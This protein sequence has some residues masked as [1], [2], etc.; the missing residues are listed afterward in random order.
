MNW[1]DYFTRRCICRSTMIVKLLTQC[2]MDLES[3]CLN[4]RR[5][6]INA[7]ALMKQTQNST[8]VKSGVKARH[9]HFTETKGEINDESYL[10][11]MF[12]GVGSFLMKAITANISLR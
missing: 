7:I 4:M 3:C 12:F 9:N 5:L 10:Q 1:H 8:F 6:A 2:L 11:V